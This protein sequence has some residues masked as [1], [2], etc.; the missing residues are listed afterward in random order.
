M[1]EHEKVHSHVQNKRIVRPSTT[2]TYCTLQGADSISERPGRA[3]TAGG[4]GGVRR[5]GEDLG[6]GDADAG[7]ARRCTKVIF[8]QT[9]SLFKL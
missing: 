6:G 9:L 3:E 7:P 2:Y 8:I 1:V 5:G 4:A